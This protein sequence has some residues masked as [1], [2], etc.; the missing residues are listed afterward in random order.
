[1]AEFVERLVVSNPEANPLIETFQALP[2]DRFGRM[3][4]NTEMNASEVPPRAFEPA[5]PAPGQRAV[6]QAACA[7]AIEFWAQ[8]AADSRL[9]DDF[10][11]TAADNA[12]VLQRLAGQV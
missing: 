12:Q 3:I 7:A 4:A 5:L 11:A 9:S 6:W 1:M 2:S 10:R 8:A